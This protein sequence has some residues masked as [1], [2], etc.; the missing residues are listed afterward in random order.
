MCRHAGVNNKQQT[1]I[2]LTNISFLCKTKYEL[3]K[4]LGRIW[5]NEELIGLWEYWNRKLTTEEVSF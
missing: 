2:I 3:I 5:F 1:T 4:M